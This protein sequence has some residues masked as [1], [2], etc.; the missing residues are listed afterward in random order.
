[1]FYIS[2]FQDEEKCTKYWYTN[3]SHLRK[4]THCEYDFYLH[5]FPIF[6]WD[7]KTFYFIIYASVLYERVC[8]Y[9]QCGQN[10]F[11]HRVE[12]SLP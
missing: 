7:R 1:M 4:W 2:K 8:V 11:L 6:E 10:Y 12:V 9:L 5:D 3:E